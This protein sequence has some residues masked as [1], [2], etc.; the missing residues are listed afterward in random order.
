MITLG[1]LDPSGEIIDEIINNKL[2]QYRI[3]DVDFQ[4]V[5]VTEDQMNRFNHVIRILKLLE[6]SGVIAERDPS[7]KDMA[8]YFKSKLMHSRHMPQM[9][10][11][12]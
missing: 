8:K 6:S 1:D 3:F 11:V 12:I 9:N 7:S 4:R 5:A 10:S 2:I